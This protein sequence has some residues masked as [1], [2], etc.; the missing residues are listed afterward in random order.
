MPDGKYDPRREKL[1]ELFLDR[2][3]QA[4]V[5]F[6][7]FLLIWLYLRLHGDFMMH[8]SSVESSK[9]IICPGKNVLKFPAQINEISPFVMGVVNFEVNT[10][11][12]LL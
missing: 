2:R 6:S 7:Q 9:F 5:H 10:S 11:R 1:V 3:F 12:L 8:E 4:G